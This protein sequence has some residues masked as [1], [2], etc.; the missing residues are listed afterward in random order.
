[1]APPDTLDAVVIHELLHLREPTHGPKF[2]LLIATHCP[3]YHD[4][5]R[6]LSEHEA[7]LFQRFGAG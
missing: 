7:E 1:M 5:M 2:W 4:R 3:N 6:W